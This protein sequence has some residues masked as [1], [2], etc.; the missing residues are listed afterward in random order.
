MDAFDGPPWLIPTCDKFEVLVD[1]KLESN[2]PC[3]FECFL[4]WPFS[5]G[6]EA[7][8]VTDLIAAGL[9]YVECKL[10]LLALPCDVNWEYIG[11]A[12]ELAELCCW[13]DLVI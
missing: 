3:E 9:E 12:G 7:P 13:R 5:I 4:E 2:N 10:A 11:V 6:D 1:G 8:C